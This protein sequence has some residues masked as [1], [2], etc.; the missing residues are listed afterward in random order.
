[1]YQCVLQ[2]F[3]SFTVV[4]N[5]VN[6]LN[7]FEHEQLQSVL[8]SFKDVFPQDL[9]SGLPP[10]RAVD[11]RIDLIPG[12]Q[13]VSIPPYQM[14]QLEE[15]ELARQ[16][17]NYLQQGYIRHSK[18]PWGA[19]VLLRKKKDGTWRMCVDYKRLN[20]LTIKNRYPLPRSDDLIDRFLSATYF[21]KND[22]RTG[23]HKRRIH[24]GHV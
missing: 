16:L 1:M 5:D 9:P 24:P 17:D 15:D 19:P 22:L 23:Y 18:S 2:P 3:Y 6:E 7:V 11:H 4:S 8:E 21:T 13:P 12:A 14:S 20:K 10:P